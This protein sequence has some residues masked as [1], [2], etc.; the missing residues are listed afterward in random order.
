MRKRIPMGLAATCLLLAGLA[1]AADPRIERL[2]REMNR[3]SA[4]AQGA[5]GVAAIHV[6]SGR[7]AL[8][9]GSERFAMASTFKV[10][11][12][13]QLLGRID[14][15]EER[16]DRMITLRPSDL[17][18]GSGTLARLFTQPG[19]ALSVRNLLELMMLISDNS[20]TDILLRLA[21]GPEAVTAR[22]RA[23]GVDGL[24][25]DRPTVNLIADIYGVEKLPPEQEWTPEVLAEALAA[26]PKDRS[27]AAEE[28]Y[29]TDPRDTATPEA[30]AR[31]LVRVCRRDV[32]KPESADLLLDLM[33]RC[34]TGPARIH[35]MLPE[36]TPVA[37]KT[38]TG[39]GVVNDVGIITLPENA[40]H[41]ALAVFVRGPESRE[42]ASERAIA[43]VSRAVYDFFLYQRAEE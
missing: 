32:L 9:N 13:V 2:E 15:A 37:H 43:Q 18:P 26:V 1:P 21:G 19:V 10:P 41:V 35:G 16:L 36:G 40:G 8:L 29:S 33:R 39:N 5:I 27:K 7:M 34:Q 4:G 24:R 12:A 42:T 30:M 28:R 23:L 3:I 20:A 11:I 22:M 25:V 17:H 6:E 31:L 38:G 14:R